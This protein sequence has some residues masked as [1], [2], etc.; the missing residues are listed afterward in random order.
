MC[1]AFGYSFWVWW[2]FVR[3]VRDIKFVWHLLWG[4]FPEVK[5]VEAKHETEI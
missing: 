5:Q 3:W 4:A 2:R 1:E